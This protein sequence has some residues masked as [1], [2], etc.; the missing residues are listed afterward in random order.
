ML[1]EVEGNI[2]RL[3]AVWYLYRH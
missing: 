3:C 1:K 2:V